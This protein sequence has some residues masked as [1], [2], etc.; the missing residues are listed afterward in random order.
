MGL[1][2]PVLLVALGFPDGAVPTAITTASIFLLSCLPA[3][4][5]VAWCNRSTRRELAALQAGGYLV[6]WRY[7]QGE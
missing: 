3:A 1:P 7:R 5:L 2:G 6:C 4:A